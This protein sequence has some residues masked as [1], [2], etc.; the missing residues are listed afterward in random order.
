MILVSDTATL[1]SGGGKRPLT[2]LGGPWTVII[3]VKLL[4]QSM[5]IG[6]IIP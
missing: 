4:N 1:R 5:I 3:G 6:A 2:K